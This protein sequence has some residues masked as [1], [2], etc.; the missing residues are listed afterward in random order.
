M[1]CMN[2]YTVH[3]ARY[4]TSVFNKKITVVFLRNQVLVLRVSNYKTSNQVI[5]IQFMCLTVDTQHAPVLDQQVTVIFLTI[6]YHQYS[7]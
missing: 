2:P 1:Q 5:L 4:T 6:K 3:I 7:I